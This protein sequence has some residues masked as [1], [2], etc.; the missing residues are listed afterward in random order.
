MSRTS[1]LRSAAVRERATVPQQVECGLGEK[2]TPWSGL[3]IPCEMGL[4]D[5]RRLR[6]SHAFPRR[7]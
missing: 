3:W 2:N 7:K 5:L 4:S 1:Q 6:R